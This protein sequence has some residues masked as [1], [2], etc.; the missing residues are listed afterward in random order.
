MWFEEEFNKAVRE[1]DMNSTPGCCVL[2]RL[3]TTNKE[4]LKWDGLNCDPE[5]VAFVKAAVRQRFDALLSGVKVS[6]DLNVF[7]KQE[8]HK[9]AKLREGRERLIL[10]VSL[11]DTFVDRILFGWLGRL[12]VSTVGR[13]PCMVGWSPVRGGWRLLNAHYKRKRVTCLDKSAWDWTVTPW[14]VRAWRD[15]IRALPVNA[16]EWWLDMVDARFEQLFEKAVF[17]FKDGTVVFQSVV[18]IMKSGCYLTIILNSVGQSLLHYVAN[19]RLG[20]PLKQD[21]PHVMGD[22]TVQPLVLDLLAYVEQIRR[23]G[24]VVKEVSAQD[25]V[26][27]AGFVFTDTG[28][29]PCYWQ[30]HLFSLQY[31]ENLAE[32]VYSYQLLY[33]HEPVMFAFL[34]RV[35]LELGPEHVVPYNVARTVMD[36]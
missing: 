29:W 5:R 25:F 33:F 24:A 2:N 6:D 31:A 17:R 28:A 7:V 35:A 19:S 9:V 23:L 8:P 15:F 12:V 10:A 18:G 16:P 34:N 3:G 21:Q 4:I 30:K 14:M 32:T 26:E 22:D 27:F 1:L 36:D 13:T 20:Y 11:I